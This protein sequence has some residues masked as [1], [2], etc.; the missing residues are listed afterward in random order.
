M[1]TGCHLSVQEVDRGGLIWWEN[2]GREL[3]K[4]AEL[5]KMPS[6]GSAWWASG[7]RTDEEPLEDIL[8]LPFSS[9]SKVSTFILVGFGN[10]C[11]YILDQQYDLGIC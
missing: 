10:F 2:L 7:Q 4:E 5:V 11:A 6:Q 8:H 1:G 9:P 3:G